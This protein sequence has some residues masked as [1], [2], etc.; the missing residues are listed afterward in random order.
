MSTVVQLFS[1]LQNETKE[2]L[3]GVNL[4]VKKNYLF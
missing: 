4:D 2:K 1:D 3:I